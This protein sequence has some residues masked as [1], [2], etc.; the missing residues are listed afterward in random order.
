VTLPT[1]LSPGV[2]K[3]FFGGRQKK[4]YLP[5][6]PNDNDVGVDVVFNNPV[7]AVDMSIAHGFKCGVLGVALH[8]LFHVKEDLI[9][10]LVNIRFNMKQ[11]LNNL[12]Q[13]ADYQEFAPFVQ[14]LKQHVMDTIG[15]PMNLFVKYLHAL[16][17]QPSADLVGLFILM[18]DN[19]IEQLSC[20]VKPDDMKA[21][22]LAFRDD[23]AELSSFPSMLK[24]FAV[25]EESTRSG[26]HTFQLI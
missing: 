6:I 10:P 16:Q 18:V 23:A 17:Q 22:M 24:Y 19:F 20:L 13:S 1:F 15:F 11:A 25:T 2:K 12:L 14:F 7:G 3:Q 21:F 26:S 8:D 5:G 9:V 4:L